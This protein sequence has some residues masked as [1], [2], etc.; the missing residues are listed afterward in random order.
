M[1]KSRLIKVKD[2]QPLGEY[3]NTDIDKLKKFVEFRILQVAPFVIA[4][5]CG[6]TE[7]VNKKK[8]DKLKSFHTWTTD[9]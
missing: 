1:Y 2:A 8:L 5:R 7:I 9:F 4:W 3:K 6:K